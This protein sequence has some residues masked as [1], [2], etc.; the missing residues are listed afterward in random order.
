MK[1]ESNG[2]FSCFNLVVYLCV[3]L[4][5]DSRKRMKM[6]IGPKLLFVPTTKR[7][8]CLRFGH[9]KAAGFVEKMTIVQFHNL[10]S[11]EA[12]SKVQLLGT[13]ISS[14]L[15]DSPTSVIA[16][17]E[18]DDNFL[19]RVQKLETMVVSLKDEISSLKD[20]ISSLKDKISSLK[21]RELATKLI[22]NEG[23]FVSTC[24]FAFV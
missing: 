20:E 12:A 9:D 1:C 22:V 21:E 10:I 2:D 15:I 5:M 16:K 14:N 13:K 19:S 8:R 17:I 24:A 7:H 18:D 23:Y 11:Q 3:V 4:A 6:S